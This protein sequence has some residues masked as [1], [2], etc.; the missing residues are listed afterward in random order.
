MEMSPNPG[1]CPGGAAAPA[2]ALGASAGSRGQGWGGKTRCAAFFL[3]VF[4]ERELKV[5]D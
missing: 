4:F 3:K 1:H 2:A 5:I